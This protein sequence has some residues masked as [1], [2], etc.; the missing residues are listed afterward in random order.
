MGY[1]FGNQSFHQGQ[2]E[3]A[4]LWQVNKTEAI[5]AIATGLA[6][7]FDNLLTP[8]VR[9]M[10]AMQGTDRSRTNRHDRRIAQAL[11]CAERAQRLVHR[12]LDLA[13][14]MPPDEAPVNIADL[15][16]GMGD[17]FASFLP[18]DIF[19]ELDLPCD[20]PTV[21]IDRDRLE[22]ALLNLVINA[23]DAMPDGGKI[24]VAVAQEVF[25][26]ASDAGQGRRML[27]L[28]VTDT[29]TGMDKLTLRRAAEP[30]F[31]TKDTGTGTGLGLPLV[32]AIV[33]QLDGHFSMTS[34]VGIGT[35]IDLWLPVA[36]TEAD[37]STARRCD[38]PAA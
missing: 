30:F 2:D 37:A 18:Q 22:T 36:E 17:I 38:P 20:L 8:L 34:K 29:G 19:L 6:H 31:S 10:T 11:A 12:I 26:S 28:S 1:T 24:T 7:D 13:R 21:T 16:N 14:V 32:C 3:I 4:V 27:R 33:K 15:L 9:T 23:R 5:G 35:T 25:L